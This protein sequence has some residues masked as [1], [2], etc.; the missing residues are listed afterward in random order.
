[1]ADLIDRQEAIKRLNDYKEHMMNA[2]NDDLIEMV[3]NSCIELLKL[4]LPADKPCPLYGG[5]D[6]KCSICGV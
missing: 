1:M 2:L 4:Q 3:C 6:D 5:N